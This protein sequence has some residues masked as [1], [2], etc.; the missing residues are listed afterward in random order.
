MHDQF[1]HLKFLNELLFAVL[2]MDGAEGPE[3]S[4]AQF[5][6]VYQDNPEVSILFYKFLVHILKTMK[7]N[8]TL[9]TRPLQ[10]FELLFT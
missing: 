6:L 1:Y 4:G 3:G 9:L 10:G 7:T 8:Q 5:H 2:V